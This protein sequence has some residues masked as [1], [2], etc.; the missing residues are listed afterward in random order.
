MKDHFANTWTNI[1]R[2]PYQS[3]AAVG[4]LW[5]TFFVISVVVLLAAGSQMVLRYFETRPQATAFFKDGVSQEEIEAL[6]QQLT[7]TGKIKELRF[8]SKQEALAIYREQNKNDPL[9]LEMVTADILPASLEVATTD[10][11]YLQ[12]VVDILQQNEGVE[13]VIFQQE[14]VAALQ[15]LTTTVRRVGLGI[16]AFLSLISFLIVMVIISLKVAAK[17]TEIKILHLIGAS[18]SYIRLPFVFEGIFYGL[19]GAFWGWGLAYL[20]VLY[21]TPLLVKFF[22]GINLLPIPVLLM[23]ALLGVELMIGILIGSLSGFLAA[24]RYFK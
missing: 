8:V 3:L 1:R 5:L 24:K 11:S 7:A 22:A 18:R 13:E 9:L 23:L 20:I 14:I 10:L 16:V 17:K 4:V 2:S 21:S 12:G 6:K 19:I 15:N